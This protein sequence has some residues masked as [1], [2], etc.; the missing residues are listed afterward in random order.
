MAAVKNNSSIA[1]I[2]SHGRSHRPEKHYKERIEE[3][4]ER[5]AHPKGRGG[6][7]KSKKLKFHRFFKLK[8]MTRTGEMIKSLK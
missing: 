6:D 2:A 7:R 4:T 8:V 3:L 1:Y 5:Q